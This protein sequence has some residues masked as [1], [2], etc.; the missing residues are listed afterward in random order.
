MWVVP[1]MGSPPMP[2]AV[3]WPMPRVREL[4]DGFVGEGAGFRDDADG[5]LLVD[6]AGHDADLGLAGGDDAGAVGADEAGLGVLDDFPDFDHVEDGDAFGDADDEGDA[7]GGGFEDAVGGGGWRDEDD[8]GVGAGFLDGFF[9]G[10][11]D[12]QAFVRG[13]A[14]AGGDSADDS[15]CRI[16]GVFVAAFGVEGPSRPVMP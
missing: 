9:D 14:F 1:M 5:A 8:G 16:V 6:A 10:V 2:M 13:A 7:G 3:D 4:V 12:G 11:E 15:C